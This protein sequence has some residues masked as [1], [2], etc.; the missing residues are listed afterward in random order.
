MSSRFGIASQPPEPPPRIIRRTRFVERGHGGAWKVAFADFVTAMMALFM[1]LWLASATD[2]AKV[3]VASSN[4][5]SSAASFGT[6]MTCRKCAFECHS[7][8]AGSTGA[9]PWAIA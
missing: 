4:T 5:V 9:E 3:A 7:G 1:V 6:L 2:E 8:A